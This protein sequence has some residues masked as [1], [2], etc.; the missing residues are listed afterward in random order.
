ME[1]RI[2]R[3]ALGEVKVPQ[4]AYYGS[5]TA[6]S[7]QFFAIGWEKMP[8]E[9]IDS[10]A[11]IKKTCAQ[12]NYELGEIQKEYFEVISKVAD[13]ILEGKL[14]KH[15][16]L[17]VWQTGSGTQT[18]MNV[19]EVIA[20]RANEILGFPHSTKYPIHPNDHV[21]KSQ[22][23]NDVFPS[24]MNISTVLKTKKQLLPA[25]ENL[26]KILEEKV[27]EFKGII[28]IGR[29]HLMDAVPITF[30]Q[31]FSGYLRQVELGIER[32]QK[33][34]E[35]LYEIPLGGTA[36]GTGL[37]APP[38]FDKVA[39]KYINEFTGEHFT[40]A[41]NKFE[42]LAGHD[43]IVMLSGA[44]K[45]LACALMKI[46]NDIRLMGSG[47]R[48]GLAEL[49]LPE[50]EPGSSIMPGKVN[51]TQCE[52]MTMIC[53]QVIGNDVTISLAGS[54]GQLELNVYKPVIAYNILQSI[55]L[56]SDGCKSFA[57]NCIKG[58]QVNTQ[59][60]KFYIENSLMLIT[61][62][63]KKIGYENASKIARDAYINNTTLKEEC[64]KSG[65]I[66]P[67]EFDEIVDPQKMISP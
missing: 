17:S 16:P 50:N 21:N 55:Q 58:L 8:K 67:E 54:L 45:T 57:E 25:L 29:T 48:C 59:R 64:I 10:L 31:E 36:V 26:K 47:P 9:I 5:Q 43:G 63:S 66:T 62:L 24:A 11:I 52:M 56:L 60:V 1:F 61:A 49:I 4:D 20:T 13:E 15:F 51:P 32:I 39:I 53:T 19:N 30:G 28:K 44:L 27:N 65:I 46:A 3:D 2:E 34:L 14:D 18:N 41:I 37:N 42:G 33:S 23:S 12:A 38:N 7:L 40:P 22:S 6:R 35:Y